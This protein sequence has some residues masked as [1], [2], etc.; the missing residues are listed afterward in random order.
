MLL[1]RT[2]R[3][4]IRSLSNFPNKN[5]AVIS[6]LISETVKTCESESSS[7][8]SSSARN[9]QETALNEICILVDDNDRVTGSTTKADC[10]RV[11]Q[12]NEIKL[13]RAFSV[14]LFNS[15]GDMLIQRRSTSKVIKLKKIYLTLK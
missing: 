8:I 15:D 5:Q 4:F 14:F 13:H 10:H 3:I 1:N 7:S 12:N 2:Q 11:G 9:V 6:P